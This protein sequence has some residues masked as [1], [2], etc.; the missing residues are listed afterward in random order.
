MADNRSAR[1]YVKELIMKAIA[2]SVVVCLLLGMGSSL[3]R[4][5]EKAAIQERVDGFT[6]AWNAHDPERMAALWVED[7][8]VINPFGRAA[9]GRDEV[10]RLFAD[11]QAGPM[12]QSRHEMRVESV[13]MVGDLALVDLKS[14]ITGIRGEDDRAYPPLN[15]HIFNV[16]T[17]RDGE[18][19]II[20]ARPYA[21]LPP[22]GGD[23]AVQRP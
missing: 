3:A 16:M 10:R 2:T 23:G 5:D 8:D 20:S 21:L 4:A 13:R 17:R 1:H 19:M 7:G 18:W 22:P 15:L 9:K 14:T 12:R 6:A 11:E